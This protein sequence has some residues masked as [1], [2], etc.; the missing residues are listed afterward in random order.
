MADFIVLAALIWVMT[1]FIGDP[2]RR[3]IRGAVT[4]ICGVI[5]FLVFL[6]AHMFVLS[7]ILAV[8]LVLYIIYRLIT[9]PAR[10]HRNRGRNNHWPPM[11]PL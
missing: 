2:L 11:P 9:R 6:A 4:A 10:D 1:M 3:L 8:V 5:L 7:I